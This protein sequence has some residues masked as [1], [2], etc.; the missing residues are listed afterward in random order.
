ML[1]YINT[2]IEFSKSL[3]ET[4]LSVNVSE[5]SNKENKLTYEQCCNLIDTNNI[6]CFNIMGGDYDV[7]QVFTLALLLES[8]YDKSIKLAWSSEN[9]S[10]PDLDTDILF[11]G[12]PF[13][14]IKLG[15]LSITNTCGKL[16][17]QNKTTGKLTCV[18]HRILK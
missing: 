1:W 10:F 6:T 4:I 18:T 2:S 13:D 15:S 7:N 14:Y 11:R 5:S 16:Y 17:Y 9:T 8:K 3:N 12:V